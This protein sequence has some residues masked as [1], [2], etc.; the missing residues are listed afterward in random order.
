MTD[1][2][3]ARSWQDLAFPRAIPLLNSNKR[4]RCSALTGRR[5]PSLLGKRA[6]KSDSPAAQLAKGAARGEGLW[7]RRRG[8]KAY[9]MG[10]T[11]VSGSAAT[12][13]K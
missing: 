3:A 10:T 4:K 6:R 9:S 12:I 11:M 5:F 1:R 13:I 7:K 8:A 2:R